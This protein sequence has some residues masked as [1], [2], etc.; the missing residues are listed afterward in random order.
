[1]SRSRFNISVFRASL[2]PSRRTLYVRHRFRWCASRSGLYRR[3][4]CVPYRPWSRYQSSVRLRHAQRFATRHR[5]NRHSR[6]SRQ[7]TPLVSLA[8]FKGQASRAV[9]EL[10]GFDSSVRL[11]TSCGLDRFTKLLQPCIP[12]RL[13]RHH[14]R[15]RPHQRDQQLTP[16]DRPNRQS[17][18]TVPRSP[19][20]HR[21][22]TKERNN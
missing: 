17:D 10:D 3:S 19:R 7:A 20:W 9:L 12:A 16:S 13:E 4:S 18:T 6:I 1:M 11:R 15:S 5:A 21:G 22:H 8:R 14:F 2:S